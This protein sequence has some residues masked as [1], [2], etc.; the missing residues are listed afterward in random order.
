MS[1]FKRLHLKLLN[2]V[3]LCIFKMVLGGHFIWPRTIWTIFILRLSKSTLTETK[4]LWFQ[5]SAVSWNIIFI[6]LSINVV[7]MHPFPD[8]DKSQRKGSL[9]A[10]QKTYP[11]G[12]I[13]DLFFSWLQ[14]LKLPEVPIMT[15]QSFPL[16]SCFK[17]IFH[18]SMLKV[19]MYLLQLLCLYV[20]PLHNPLGF[21]K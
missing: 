3:I 17:W 7:V 8:Y 10:C 9:K 18:F 2:I 11:T 5:L 1:V 14:Q 13:P 20:L 15:S 4:I 6:K 12:N 19:Y 16:G 21:H